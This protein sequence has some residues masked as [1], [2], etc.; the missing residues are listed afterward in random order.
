MKYLLYILFILS[1]LSASSQIDSLIRKEYAYVEE[2]GVD[3][4]SDGAGGIVATV[5]D[6]TLTYTLKL[7]NDYIA[8]LQIDTMIGVFS[9]FHPDYSWLG[10]WSTN[11]DTL[12]VEFTKFT[13]LY[14]FTLN[15][16][17]PKPEIVELPSSIIKRFIIGH[18]YQRKGIYSVTEIREDDKLIVYR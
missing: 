6:T 2:I 18:N 8:T 15:G 9:G 12:Y 5:A 16:E 17:K 1:N 3:Y 4:F 14:H 13:T 7:E 10:K 11:N